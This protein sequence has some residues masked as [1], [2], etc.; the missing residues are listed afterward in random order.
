MALTDVSIKGSRPKDKAY[1]LSD[2][3]G[4][5]ILVQPNG[6]KY[7]RLKY[8]ISGK[9]KLLSIGSY[10]DVTLAEAREKG[11]IAKKQIANNTDPSQ[12]KKE[13]KLKSLIDS[14]N[15]FEAVAR[16][17]HENQKERWVEGHSARVL[18]R[19]EANIFP[20]LGFKAIN[21]IKAP[22]LLA[23]IRAIEARGA[24]DISR[25][26]LQTCGQIF[27]YAIATGRADR[28]ISADLKGAL[29]T[30]KQENHAY[31]SAKE[32]PEFLAKLKHY[33]G[34][35]QTKLALKLVILTFLRTTEV[36]GAKWSEI[37]F[38]KQEWR[39]PAERMKM[40]KSHMVP[41]SA[42]SVEI[43][44]KLHAINGAYE[45]IF[46]NRN[47][48]TAYMSQNTM[49]YAVYRLGYHSRTTVHGFRATASTILNEHG[50]MS[51]VIERQLAHVEMNKVRASYN[52][53][54][55]LPERIKMMQW[56]G[57]YVANCIVQ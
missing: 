43:L 33:D 42:Q 46:P 36:R 56:W 30:R 6:A 22:E 52:H 16:C 20:T 54:E 5:Y 9:E 28:D 12:S 3:G 14:E 40:R 27:R 24:L 10:P 50:F 25:R 29:K 31:L 37:D 17:W 15:S 21:S 1:K 55:Y 19:L 47:N 38:E 41:L 35:E 48:P 44:K 7:W 18:N 45:H 11:A 13:D 34:D 57:D 39:V 49:I 8:R 26:A 51:D 23:V 32:L 53:A 4:L 2:S